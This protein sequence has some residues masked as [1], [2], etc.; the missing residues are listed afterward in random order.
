MSKFIFLKN[1]MIK[2]LIIIIIIL[3]FLLFLN[4]PEHFTVTDFDKEKITFPYPSV[5]IN[6]TET[7]EGKRRWPIV[8][9]KYPDA[10][11]WPATYG[12]NYDFTNDFK[13]KIMTDSWDFGT[14]KYG[15]QEIKKMTPGELGVSHSHLS[16]WKKVAEGDTPVVIL[17]DDAIRTNEHTKKRLETIFKDIPKDFDIYLLGYYDIKPLEYNKSNHNK[18]K[19]FVLMHS[20][21]VSPK[22]ARKLLENLPIDKPLDTW[23]SGLSD[24]LKIYR[25]NFY[26]IGSKGYVS[27]VIRQKRAAKQIEN[28]NII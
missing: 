13:N 4:Y 26:T 14:W 25:H 11:R 9:E 7:D 23:M 18:V 3:F 17:E 15:K 27:L 20:Y 5:I 1:I 28:T 19:E 2:A 12:K 10:K 22:G 24:K 6:L 8:S 21:I 16:I